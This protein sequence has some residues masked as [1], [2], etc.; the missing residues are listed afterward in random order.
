MYA[1]HWSEHMKILMSAFHREQSGLRVSGCEQYVML[2]QVSVI[3]TLEARQ[4]LDAFT[5]TDAMTPE[6]ENYC[7]IRETPVDTYRACNGSVPGTIYGRHFYFIVFE[8]A[9]Q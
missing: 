7:S 6:F 4:G 1:D 3:Y 2:F 9:H 8:R 5:G